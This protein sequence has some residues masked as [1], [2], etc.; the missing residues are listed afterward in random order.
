MGIDARRISLWDTLRLLAA[1][2]VPAL[3]WGLVAPNRLFVPLLSRLN[4]GQ[5]GVRL[6][7]E[8]RRKYGCEHLWGW[9]PFRR[10]LLVLDPESID[11][12]SWRNSSS[13]PRWLPCSPGSGS[14]WPGPASNRARSPICGTISRSSCERSPVHE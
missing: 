4:A 11:A 2:S 8:L 9:F 7:D 12:G 5:W 13:R 1:V 10:T 3:L 14:T 6:L